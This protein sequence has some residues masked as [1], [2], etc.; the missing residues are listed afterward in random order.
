MS[1]T[2]MS[3]SGS[4]L[5][6]AS[7]RETPMYPGGRRSD[8]EPGRH[9]LPEAGVLCADC[10]CASR[11]ELLMTAGNRAG[12]LL[13]LHLRRVGAAARSGQGRAGFGRGL[14][15]LYREDSR[16]TIGMRG[17]GVS[18]LRQWTRV[19]GLRTQYFVSTQN[20]W[21]LE[22]GCPY[23]S[24]WTRSV[25]SRVECSKRFWHRPH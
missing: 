12:L 21:R 9:R 5:T 2:G 13:S 20:P 25:A 19:P 15:T 24:L 4:C 16:T 6:P 8:R 1:S 17:K 18:C 3:C 14:R 22:Q 11:R 23:W 7:R 10:D